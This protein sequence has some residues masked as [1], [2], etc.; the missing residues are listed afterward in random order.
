MAPP[1]LSALKQEHEQRC[2]SDSSLN[3]PMP[4]EIPFLPTWQCV[5]CSPC[6]PCLPLSQH[7][8][9]IINHSLP[10]H[11]KTLTVVP[12]TMLS[13]ACSPSK[14]LIL[15]EL[16]RSTFLSPISLTTFITSRK[17]KKRKKRLMIH[18]RPSLINWYFRDF[19][20]SQN[21]PQY[22]YIFFPHNR[23]VAYKP[24]VYT[25]FTII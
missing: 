6:A 21:V 24:P 16:T 8:C 14:T 15:P 17:G 4:G 22:I 19:G 10:P 1:Q 5:L 11:Q 12:E 9:Y 20:S 3:L 13:S 7:K 2:G 18:P 25:M 23:N